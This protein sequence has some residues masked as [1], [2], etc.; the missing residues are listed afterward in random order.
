VS[1]LGKLHPDIGAAIPSLLKLLEHS[2]S[3]VR[4][5]ASSL[6]EMLGSH[7]GLYSYAIGYSSHSVVEFREAIGAAI[8]SLFRLL[9]HPTSEVRSTAS[10]LLERLGGHGE[11]YPYTI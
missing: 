7:G 6:L 1:T 11:L 8:P 10:S 9:E 2:T 3:K 4:S 5:A